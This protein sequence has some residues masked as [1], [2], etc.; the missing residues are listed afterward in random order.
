MENDVQ[1]TTYNVLFVCTGNT[2]RSP[3]AESVAKREIERRGW[4][5]VKV[6]SAGV[7]ANVGAAAS[8][9]AYE[10][11]AE[12][13][14]DLST[15]HARLMDPELVEWADLILTMSPAHLAVIDDFGAGH[16]AALLGDFVAGSEGAGDPVPDPFGGGV[17]TYRTT[18]TELERLVA[19]A[20][21]RLETIVRP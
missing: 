2:C 10:V 15:H 19:R 11:I 5:N 9:Q 13:G 14:L 3:M 4:S 21:D 16:K 20:L 8:P 6:G 18:L 1:R 17:S 12:L 7:A